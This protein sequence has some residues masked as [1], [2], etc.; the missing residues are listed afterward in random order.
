MAA[1]F[2]EYVAG[3]EVAKRMLAWIEATPQKDADVDEFAEYYGL[4]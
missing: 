3:P 4:V 1:A 2:L